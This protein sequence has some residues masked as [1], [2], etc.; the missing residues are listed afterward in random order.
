MI[1]RLISHHLEL[2]GA[3]NRASELCDFASALQAGD[4]AL[5]GELCLGGYQSLGDEF[6]KNIIKNIS[7]SLKDGAYLGFSHIIDGFNEFV[8]LSSSGIEFS[9]KKH[10]LFKPNNED[11]VTKSADIDQIQIHSINGLKIGVLICFE[12]RFIELWSRLKG[13]DIILVP[14]MWGKSRARD[15]EILC[16]A[17][18]M[19]NRCFVVSCSDR[20]L[21][22]NAI[23]SPRGKSLNQMKF[24][25]DLIDN[26]KRSLGIEN[27]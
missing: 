24:D 9:Q 21:E 16:E 4:L 18:A 19:Q 1:S 2:K 25:R 13:A 14:A 8:L 27:E 10:K 26:F 11:K 7:N 15:Y 5:C 12:I 6:A 17:L 23:F 22:F 3:I 20:D